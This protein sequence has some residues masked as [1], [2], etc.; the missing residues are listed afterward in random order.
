MKR[1]SVNTLLLVACLGSTLYVGFLVSQKPSIQE[2]DDRVDT[3]YTARFTVARG[4]ESVRLRRMIREALSDPDAGEKESVFV[5]DAAES[6]HRAKA[7]E[8][9]GTQEQV[10]PDHEKE[11]ADTLDAIESGPDSQ[12]AT[13]DLENAGSESSDRSDDT[14]EKADRENSD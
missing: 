3:I 14:G 6:G 4:L 9:S 8:S 11:L 12:S 5:E 2:I 7:K 10:S 13:N 1:E